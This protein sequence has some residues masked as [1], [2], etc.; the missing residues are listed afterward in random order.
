[1]PKKLMIEARIPRKDSFFFLI[2]ITTT[3]D[4]ILLD[5]NFR[6]TPTSRQRGFFDWLKSIKEIVHKAVGFCNSSPLFW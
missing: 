2:S 4:V 1:M 6:E 5:M 3:I